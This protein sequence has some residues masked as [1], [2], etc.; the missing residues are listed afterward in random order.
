V[1]FSEFMHLYLIVRFFYYT[2]LY[3]YLLRSVLVRCG[4]GAVLRFG[5]DLFRSDWAS[6][7]VNFNLKNP[8]FQ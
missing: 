5:L 1:V 4:V 7:N 2:H 8:H 6:P 3:L